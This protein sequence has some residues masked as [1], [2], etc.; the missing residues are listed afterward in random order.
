MLGISILTWYYLA[1]TPAF[2]L[3]GACALRVLVFSKKANALLPVGTAR[4]AVVTNNYSKAVIRQ[5]QL[6]AGGRGCESVLSRVG[7]LIERPMSVFTAL[8]VFVTGG[9]EK[10]SSKAIVDVMTGTL[11]A[12]PVVY[13]LTRVLGPNLLSMAA[14]LSSS[15]PSGVM[16]LVTLPVLAAVIVQRYRP[17]LVRV[18]NL[19]PSAIPVVLVS[20]AAMYLVLG[21]AATAAFPLDRL[22]A[23]GLML[24]GMV[25]WLVASNAIANH[26]ALNG[27]RW[28]RKHDDLGERREVD[29]RPLAGALLYTFVVTLVFTQLW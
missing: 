20:A 10:G 11:I 8:V 15:R 28:T 19:Q 22:A 2:A 4:D 16:V 24:F 21:R 7:S 26:F 23:G 17:A 27:L 6:V 1:L 25:S 18:M 29:L 12:G 13:A 3:M 5:R 9:R 14:R